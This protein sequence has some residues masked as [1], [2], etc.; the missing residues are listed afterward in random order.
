MEQYMDLDLQVLVDMLAESTKRFSVMINEGT[1][2]GD[3]YLLCK[4]QIVKLQQAIL[5]K[6]EFEKN[7][8][9]TGGN[10]D[11]TQDDTSGTNGE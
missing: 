11:F 1:E 3:A 4:E 5:L 9:S 8:S 10:I 2:S 7:E 6:K